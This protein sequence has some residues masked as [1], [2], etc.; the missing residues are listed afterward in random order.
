MPKP[1]REGVAL[2]ED[3][4]VSRVGHTMYQS[5]YEQVSPDQFRLSTPEK[6]ADWK[7]ISVYECSSTSDK[8]II[9]LLRNKAR[10]FIIKLK[11]G[12]VRYITIDNSKPFDVKW[13]PREDCLDS[14]LNM[15]QG[16]EKGCDGHAGLEGLYPSNKADREERRVELAKYATEKGDFYLKS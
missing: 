4:I 11:V 16:A 13:D 9:N 2:A 10:K 1:G 6:K 8:D 12:D 5:N 3:D 14:N 15:I 7:R